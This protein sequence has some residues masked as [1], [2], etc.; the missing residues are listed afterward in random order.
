MLGL[1]SSI[2]SVNAQTISVNTTYG[3]VVGQVLTDSGGTQ[4]NVFLGVPY[5]R[6]PIRGRRFR[7]PTRLAS[8]SGSLEAFTQPP[9][10]PQPLDADNSEQGDET[11]ATAEDTHHTTDTSLDDTTT[12]A[13]P[14]SDDVTPMTYQGDEDCLY[15]N[16][17]IPGTLTDYV[18]FQLPVMVFI[19]G[20][21]FLTGSAAE[22][23]A[24][25][26]AT[27]VDIAIVVVIQ[28]RL[29][30]LGFATSGDETVPGNLGLLDQVAALEWVYENAGAFGGDVNKV[31][32]VGQSS[33]AESVLLH[34]VSTPS[35]GLFQRAI[36]QSTRNLWSY[37]EKELFHNSLRDFATNNG[38]NMTSDLLQCL[39]TLPL[40]DL[41]EAHDS[42]FVQVVIDG[43][44]ITE[45]PIAT[46]E[47][48]RMH[49]VDYVIGFN[50]D[51]LGDLIFALDPG[52]QG[53]ANPATV[54][55]ILQAALSETLSQSLIHGLDNIRHLLRYDDI[56][57]NENEV[58]NLNNMLDFLRVRYTSSVDSVR[59]TRLLL[60]LLR[61]SYFTAFSVWAALSLSNQGRDVYFYTFNHRATYLGQPLLAELQLGAPHGHELHY[62]FPSQRPHGAVTLTEDEETLALNMVRA[63]KS[64]ASTG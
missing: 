54:D 26:M 64:F 8:W 22:Y 11:T 48:G 31:T 12:A 19:H 1:W 62:L 42:G 50:N 28:Y 52:M 20:G 39:Q 21:G 9:M 55:N 49:E 58:T 33:G 18:D 2:L 38:C 45:Q 27:E 57:F 10:C 41:V 3:T 51:E 30:F 46:L 56:E 53:I 60:D 5:A 43:H 37:P 35:H 25:F 6:P 63:W 15:L 47:A 16:V 61:D 36:V 14:P 17:Y 13:A 32:L 7:P 23:D 34:T 29:G 44:F 24:K 59:S 4:Y 40:S